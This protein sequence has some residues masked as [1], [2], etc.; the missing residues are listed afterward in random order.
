MKQSKEDIRM[1][2]YLIKVEALDGNEKIDQRYVDGIECDAF[3]IIGKRG[4]VGNVSIHKMSVDMIS[5]II[6]KNSDL[7]CAGI[8]A[9]AKKEIIRVNVREEI[10]DFLKMMLEGAD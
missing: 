5:D 8:L 1:A 2:K 9:K 3:C 6:V 4:E 10:P 7:M